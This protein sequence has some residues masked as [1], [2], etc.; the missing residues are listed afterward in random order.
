MNLQFNDDF[1]RWIEEHHNENP[2]VL[3]AEM[4]RTPLPFDL[5]AALTQIECRKNARANY[6]T[7]SVL[8]PVSISR[9]Y[10]RQNNRHPTA[11][12]LFIHR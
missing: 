8:R 6:Q 5:D 9:P 7:R 1:F 4:G 12:H 10:C 3:R 11:L 2:A